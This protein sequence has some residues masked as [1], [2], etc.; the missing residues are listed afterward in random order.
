MSKDLSPPNWSLRFLCWFCREDYLEEIEG[1]LPEVFKKPESG[2]EPGFVLCFK[3]VISQNMDSRKIIVPDLVN[4]PIVAYNEIGLACDEAIDKF[5][6][7][8][9]AFNQLP[10]I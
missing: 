5:V 1:D 10:E 2:K 7:V 3:F 4:M 9:I 8:P 6:V